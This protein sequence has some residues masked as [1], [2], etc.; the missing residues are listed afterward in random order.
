MKNYFQRFLFLCNIL[1]V[2]PCCKGQQ[3]KSEA[4]NKSF[5]IKLDEYKVAN[6]LNDILLSL[7]E[8]DSAHLRFPPSLY[9][10]QL[11][12]SNMVSYRT[13]ILTPS[14]W[15][16]HLPK[17]CVGVIRLGGMNF[18]CMGNF[19]KDSLFQKIGKSI[20]ISVQI[21]TVQKYD[22]LD[23]HINWFDW[24]KSPTAIV[25]KF[26]ACAGSPIDLYINVGKKL[27]GVETP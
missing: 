8:A 10:Y 21:K 22:S 1:L 7:V 24:E 14:R 27:E 2:V 13:M 5:V 6:C 4:S 12:F 17:D 20:D 3:I 25:G 15:Q 19:F 9:Y 16:K 23:S 26:G 18:L 11:Q